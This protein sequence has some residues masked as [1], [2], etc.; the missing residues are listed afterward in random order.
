MYMF[1][2]VCI[3]FIDALKTICAQYHTRIAQ[4]EEQKFDF[5]YKVATKDLEASNPP[6]KPHPQ[7]LTPT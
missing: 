3:L 1:V 4:L 2:T 6:K 7:T 5:E